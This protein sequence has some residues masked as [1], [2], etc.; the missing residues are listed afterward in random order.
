M[1]SS[2][3]A[4]DIIHRIKYSWRAPILLYWIQACNV[5]R[6]I[7]VHFL[8]VGF[9]GLLGS[10]A[11]FHL[12]ILTK[13]R[14]LGT[15]LC[16]ITGSILLAYVAHLHINDFINESLWLFSGVGF[17]GAYTTFSTFGLESLQLL[18]EIKY[19]IAVISYLSF[20]FVSI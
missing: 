12:S 20:L 5:R 2:F 15:W 6:A 16:N 9:G 19:N 8:Y 14:L 1:V 13:K 18:L 11:R 10:I 3:T 7:M 17:C 4:C